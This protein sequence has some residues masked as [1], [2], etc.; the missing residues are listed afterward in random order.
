MDL[1]CTHNDR[2]SANAVVAST[3]APKDCQWYLSDVCVPSGYVECV[4]VQ[5]HDVVPCP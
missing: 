2:G 4:G 1:G 3:G 5:P